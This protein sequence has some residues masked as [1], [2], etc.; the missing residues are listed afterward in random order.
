MAV[1]TAMRVERQRISFSAPGAEVLVVDDFPSNLLVAE[2]LLAPYQVRVSTCLNGREALEAVQKHTFDLVLMDHMM[3]EM[4]GLEATGAIR[5]LGG[6]FASLPIAA[7]TANVMS[8][9]K[10]RFLAGG[11]SDFLAKPID[12]VLLDALLRKWIPIDKQLSLPADAEDAPEEG[13][14]T[15]AIEGLE[16]I[17]GLDAAAGLARIGGSSGR[18]RELLRM[19]L[20]DVEERSDL[21]AAGP[22]TAGWPYFTTAVHALKSGLA[23]IG[24]QGLSESAA[25]LERAGREG[26]LAVIREKLASFREG[27]AALT[28]RL[29]EATAESGEAGEMASEGEWQGALAEL[30]A[31]LEA[32]DTD[33]LETAL[34][35]LQSLRVTP[36]RRTAVADLARHILFSDFKKALANVNDLSVS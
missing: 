18:Y 36:E 30:K 19:F 9:M 33:R 34:A 4:D 5:A 32:R 3:P 21:L 6:P 35:N 27:L 13:A 10:E 17:E 1:I 16:A 28:A 23:N 25:E 15:P 11:F 22:E 8:G 31:A 29:N 24:A 7:L 12:T 20:Q 14:E 2:G 26:D